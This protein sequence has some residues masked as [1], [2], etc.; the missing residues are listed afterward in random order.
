MTVTERDAKQSDRV[1][2]DERL[3]AF[4]HVTRDQAL[5]KW[6]DLFRRPDMIDD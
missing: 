3:P 1:E 6:R 4:F 2:V 5:A